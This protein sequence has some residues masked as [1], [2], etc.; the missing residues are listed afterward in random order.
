MTRG[1]KLVELAIKQQSS[2][3]STINNQDVAV[4]QEKNKC[5][6]PFL[7]LAA[8]READH[9]LEETSN[10]PL[11]PKSTKKTAEMMMLIHELQT[12]PMKSSSNPPKIILMK[13]INI[14]LLRTCLQ[15]GC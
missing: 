8:P 9:L 14:N 6:S 10:L 15:C 13:A 1:R 2:G 7:H 12:T 4:S 3:S 5:W 11:T